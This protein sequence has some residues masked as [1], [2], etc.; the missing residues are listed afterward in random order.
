MN[1]TR[2]AATT[3]A[4]VLWR[5]TR[6]VLVA[7]ALGAI[8]AFGTRGMVEAGVSD[9]W[10]WLWGIAAFLAFAG[11][12]FFW[13]ISASRRWAPAASAGARRPAPQAKPARTLAMVSA[14]TFTYWY[15]ATLALLLNVLATGILVMAVD[16]V[17]YIGG[18]IP[19][20]AACN[21]AGYFIVLGALRAGTDPGQPAGQGV[22]PLR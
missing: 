14:D 1:A 7:F 22:T 13:A 20:G 17:G 11:G 5:S 10:L 9:T 8:F 3:A 18:L 2:T 6:A 12:V 15:V 16:I 4:T 21:V 19:A